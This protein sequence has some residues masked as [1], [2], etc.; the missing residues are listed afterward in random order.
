MLAI[1]FWVFYAAVFVGGAI[2]RWPGSP[3]LSY[4]VDLLVML[5]IGALGL[6]VFPVAL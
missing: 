5:L 2:Y 1:L 3:T 6:R 4:G